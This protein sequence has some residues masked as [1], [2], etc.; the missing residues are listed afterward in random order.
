MTVEEALE[1]AEEFGKAGDMLAEIL[2]HAVA[3]IEASGDYNE[4]QFAAARR[5]IA[6]WHRMRA[7]GMR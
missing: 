4:T 5:S 6:I 3:T 2:G 7:I 1:R